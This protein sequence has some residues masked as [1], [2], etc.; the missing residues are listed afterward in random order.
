MFKK[1][2]LTLLL[3]NVVILTDASTTK[4]PASQKPPAK[5]KWGINQ[6]SFLSGNEY[7]P[8]NE[9]KKTLRF[10]HSDSWAY[11]DNYYFF[12]I[13]NPVSKNTFI[14]G[15]WHSRL[16]FSKMTGHKIGFGPISDV[17]LA[18]ELNFDG[19]GTHIYLYGLGFNLKIPGF[20]FFKLNT[21]ARRNPKYHGTTYQISWSWLLPI[22][23]IHDRLKFEFG[24][25]CDYA[26]RQGGAASNFLTKPQLLLDVGNLI[27][28]SPNNIFAGIR[29]VYW[30][31]RLGE[32]GI[33]E[34]LPE[35]MITWRIT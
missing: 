8:Y 11:G 14:Y 17:L 6:I 21:Y 19:Q 29:Y 33:T 2:I 16:S 34:S 24:G 27:F 9:H 20:R 28:N 30:H 5:N 10:D 26:G 7:A 13:T 18:G 31:N 35:L 1:T 12:D 22:N 4:T 15:E 32:K 23:L 3:I 25:F